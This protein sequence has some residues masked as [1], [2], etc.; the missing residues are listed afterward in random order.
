MQLTV[1]DNKNEHKYSYKTL[2]IFILTSRKYSD[3]TD[4]RGFFEKGP[5]AEATDAPQP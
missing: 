1:Y 2:F 4:F 5:A 3:L